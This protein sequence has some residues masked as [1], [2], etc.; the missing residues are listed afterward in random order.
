ML[1]AFL[2]CDRYHSVVVTLCIR[3]GFRGSVAREGSEMR[4]RR[5][6]EFR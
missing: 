5:A 1:K 3:I 2:N 4:R 6:N